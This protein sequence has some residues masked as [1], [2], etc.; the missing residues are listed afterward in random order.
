M[1]K[2]ALASIALCAFSAHA[3]LNKHSESVADYAVNT[4]QSAQVHTLTNLVSFPTVNKSDVSAPQNP[5][6]IGFKALLKMKAAE[7]GFDY[8]DLG[9]TVL[10]SMGQQTEKVTIV[11]HGDVQPA[12]ASK[13]KQSPF[14]I[15]T[16]EPDKL[17]GRGTEDD[18]GAIATAMYAM[19][20]IKDKG[21][22]LDNRIEL[23]IY[24]AE[25]SDWGPLTEFMKTY[26][27]PKYA[28]TIDASYPVVVAEKG[29]SL[30]AP[31]FDA[32]SPQTG[33]YVSGVTGG[34]FASQIPEDASLL[35]HNA[36]ETLINQLKAKANTL[37]QVE[38]NFTEQNNALAI[39]VKGMSAHSSEPES[40][41][42]AIAYLAEIFKGVE[43]E[44]NSD[45]QLIDFVNQLIGLDI[46]GKQFG[47]IAY[48]HDFMGPMSVAP[49]VIERE[50]NALTLAVNARRPVGK[51]ETLL[52]QQIDT[53][54][55]NWQ[56]ANQVTLANIKIT[57]GKPMLLDS[58]PHAQKLLDIF[59][60]YTGDKNA[61]F[62]S[63]G[64]GTNAK[65]FDNA[66]SFGPSMPGKRYTGHSEHEF[67]TLEQLALNLRMYTAMMIELGNM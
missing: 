13:W 47:E 20:A 65:L 19:K 41:V 5:D 3:Q 67:I 24:L 30:I 23:M 18:K 50:G 37:K 22:A 44:N 29:W 43:L 12:N 35:L 66:V 15:D 8:Q 21:I 17:I 25:E 63:I 27:Q 56:T 39:S 6:F 53:A 57:I 61:D 45:G 55:A 48:E 26:Q 60:Y 62:V 28:V 58:A 32:T 2:L 1:K 10:I 9:Y 54:L 46:Y 4:Y 7:L 34:A 51:D 16:S 38:F 36:N 64:G 31:T 14:I 40:G 49:T 33:V 59:K 52:K 11:T 42:N